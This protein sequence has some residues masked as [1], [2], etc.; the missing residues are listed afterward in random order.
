[1]KK[2]IM[3]SVVAITALAGCT[4]AKDP[5]Y[6]IKIVKAEEVVH[7]RVIGNITSSSQNYGFFNETAEK[8]R[9]GNAKMSGYNLGATHIVLAPAIENGNTTITEGKAYACPQY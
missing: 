2:V 5:Y 1:M 6:K 4:T 7:C 3:M 8:H 9:L